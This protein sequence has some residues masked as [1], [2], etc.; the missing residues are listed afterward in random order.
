MQG[1][2]HFLRGYPGALVTKRNHRGD[3]RVSFDN[4][5]E[6]FVRVF[7]GQWFIIVIVV[8]AFTMS[9]VMH[10]LN[11]RRA[12]QRTRERY[13]LLAKLAEQPRE[14]ADLIIALLREEDAKEE[15]GRLKRL[16]SHRRERMQGGAILIAVGIGIG[17]FF[18]RLLPNPGHLLWPVGVIP[19]FIGMVILAFAYFSKEDSSK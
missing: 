19:A 10:W 12:E 6:V 18:D 8:A 13:A 14:S 1:G 9:V 4:T 2:L 11:T 16:M 17:I 7:S 5:L 15:A 3:R